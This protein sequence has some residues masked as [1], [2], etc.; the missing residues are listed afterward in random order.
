MKKFS[1]R[2]AEYDLVGRKN[3]SIVFKSNNKS[4]LRIDI[5]DLMEFKG[6]AYK[7]HAV[8][9]YVRIEYLYSGFFL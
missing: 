9:Q 1:E 5:L 6:F 7:L 8:M 2:K 4:A 3:V